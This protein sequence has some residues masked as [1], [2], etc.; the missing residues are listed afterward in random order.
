MFCGARQLIWHAASA[1]RWCRRWSP[2]LSVGLSPNDRPE[3]GLTHPRDRG[4][5]RLGQIP[6]PLEQVVSQLVRALRRLDCDLLLL[7]S[8]EMRQVAMRLRMARIAK[9]T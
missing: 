4:P 9:L 8:V 1:M 7:E 2:E 5:L 6:M 3:Y